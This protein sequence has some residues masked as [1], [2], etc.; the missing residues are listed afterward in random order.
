ML[1]SLL[2]HALHFGKYRRIKSIT[3]QIFY[4][5][6]NNWMNGQLAAYS[7]VCSNYDSARLRCVGETLTTGTKI[8]G[9]T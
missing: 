2:S 3:L 8:P 6:L 4:F 9:S 7:G 1:A 5:Q